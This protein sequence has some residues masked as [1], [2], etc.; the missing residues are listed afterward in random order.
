[1]PVSGRM[2]HSVSG[3]LTYQ[4]YGG[5]GDVN[6]SISRTEL[7]RFLIDEAEKLGVTFL[8]STSVTQINEEKKSAQVKK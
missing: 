5:D 3:E 8:F 4:P 2:M 1:M 6:Y 7:N